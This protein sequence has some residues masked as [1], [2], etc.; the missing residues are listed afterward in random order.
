MECFEFEALLQ[1]RLDERLAPRCAEL[2]AHA[3]TCPECNRLAEDAALLSRGVAAWRTSLPVASSG[4]TSQMT[5]QVLA[6]L[7]AEPPAPRSIDLRPQRQLAHTETPQRWQTWIVLA[8]TVAAVWCVFLG[9]S[10]EHHAARVAHRMTAVSPGAEQLK[11][12]AD[13][14]AVLVSAEG[15]YSQL[16]NESLAA[17]QDFALLWPARSVPSTTPAAVPSGTGSEWSPVWSPELAPL[18]NS[19]EDAWNFLRR[20]VP[21]VPKSPT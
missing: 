19:V 8:G 5:E 4:L 18:S 12:K 7:R 3:A 17:A 9:S 21:Q 10:A 15:A 14:V 16:A 13:L 11:P 6:T 2:D 1:Q 20:T